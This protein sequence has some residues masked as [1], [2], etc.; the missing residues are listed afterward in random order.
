MKRMC[1]VRS[2]MLGLLVSL[3]MAACGGGGKGGKTPGSSAALAAP[4]NLTATAGDAR[5]S[6]SWNAVSG[7]RDY[8]VYQA[9]TRGGQGATPVQSGISGT[10][11][12]LAGLSNGATYYF[13]VKAANAT[14]T[15]AASNE[16]A[17]TP[18]AA[19]PVGTLGITRLELAQTH[20]LPVDGLR[21]SLTNA[22]ESLH[23]V[24]QREALAL[25]TLSRTDAAN[26]QLEGWLS[27]AQLG[28]VPLAA[29]SQLPRSE[30]GGPLYASDRYSANVPASWLRP[31]LQL[32]VTAGNYQPSAFQSPEVGADSPMSLRVLPFYLF[33]ATDATKPFDQVAVP[34]A[35]TIAEMRAKWPVA[36]LD[37]A[38]HPA[39]RANW[40]ILVNPPRNGGPAYVLHNASEMKD[41]FDVLRTTHGVVR[42][43]LEANGEAEGPIQYY[44]PIVMVNN[45]GALANV[46][47]GI[48]GSRV[49]TGDTAYRGIFIHEQGHAFGLPHQGEAYAQARYPYVG[50]SLS[51]S[52]W[53]FDTN[54]REL[55][56]PIV[57]TTADT[58][59][60]CATDTFAGYP[61]QKD[62]QGRC[63]KQDPMQSGSGDQAP[64]YRFA[65]FSDFSTAMMQRFFEGRTT[66]DGGSHSYA[67]GV[68][69]RDATYPGG[70]RRWDTLDHK[71]VDVAPATTD[72]GLYGFDMGLP[73]QRDVA[74]HAI[75]V[76]Y[77]RA[78]TAGA[79]Q[80][81]PPLSYVG[82]L[83]RYIDPTDTTQR[84]SIVPN[85]GTYPWYC[86]DGGCDFTVRVTYSNGSVRHVLLQNGFRPWF[87]PTAEPPASAGDANDG[88]SFRTWVVQVPATAAIAK[89]ELLDTPMAWN[90]L[91]ANPTV[92]ASR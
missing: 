42:G 14:T 50:G 61:R 2:L 62:A 83:R 84:A 90:G 37:V 18:M 13:I 9:S 7:A 5:V 26:A 24:G 21:W 4:A 32:R 92:L 57:P 12:T 6:L 34:D 35:A 40:P 51:G 65:T 10:S 72:K 77:S 44:A 41:G 45:V 33:G 88:N 63:I 27:G 89:V 15:S 11:V 53:G 81:Y 64:E 73:A 78:G 47:G 55:L 91:P 38:N 82:N 56:P 86:H 49:G 20:V 30:A 54:R 60:N 22:S 79:S 39:H 58:Y 74:V 87:Q 76:T 71:W 48:G 16:V 43:L 17:A 46:G 31:G 3:G 28:A 68:I 36:R 75:V 80:I 66:L 25:L 85:T 67:G 29:P 70:Y 1:L 19:L 52:A 23:L 69:V 59:R 8:S